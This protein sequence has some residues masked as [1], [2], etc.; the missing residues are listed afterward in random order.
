MFCRIT[1]GPKICGETGIMYISNTRYRSSWMLDSHVRILGLDLVQGFSLLFPDFREQFRFLI[2]VSESL[3]ED[4]VKVEI[5]DEDRGFALY[6][7]GDSGF[8][9]G[10]RNFSKTFYVGRRTIGPTQ[11]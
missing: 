9:G 10:G 3:M 5:G 4:D 2:T 7:W 11:I 1:F 6:H 8:T